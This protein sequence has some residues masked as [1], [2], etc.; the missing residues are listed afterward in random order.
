MIDSA[1]V[2][3]I[4]IGISAYDIADALGLPRPTD[5]QRDVIEAPLSPALVVAGAGSGK[6]ETMANRVL[7]LLANGHLRAGE[8]LGLTFTRKAAGELAA[9][10]RE[11]IGQLAHQGLLPGDYDE[12]EAPVV[13]TYNSFAN[14][15]YRDHAMLLGRESDG[16]VLGEA[17][18][19][20]LARSIVVASGDPRL[21]QLGRNV[22]PITKAVLE[23]SHALSENIVDP[24]RVRAMAARFA[25]IADLPAG[26]KG[27]YPAVAELVRTVGSL[28]VLLDL[29]TA[30]SE[31]KARRGFV[32]YADQVALAL[33]IVR[34]VPRVSADFRERYRVVLL[35]EYQD[36]SVVQTWLLSELF[37]DHAVMAVGDPNQSIYG[38]RGASAANLEQFAHQFGGGEVAN[39][40]LTTSWRNGRK[41]LA[42]A[43]ALVEPLVAHT[44]VRV[45][46][47]QPG[48]G[49]SAVPVELIVEETVL[50]EAQAAARWL[51]AHLART[52]PKTGKPPTAAMLFRARK[53]QPYFMDALRDNDVPFHVLGVGGLMSEPEIADLVSALRVVHD[54]TA[55][56]EL[57]RLLAGSRWRIGVRDLRALSRL[58]SWLRDRDY[59]QKSYDDEVKDALRASV[60]SGEGGSIV[61][62][63]DFL[64]T[65]KP[66]HSQLDGFSE[67]GLERLREAGRT[68]AKLRSRGGLDLLDFVTLVEQELQLDIEVVANDLRALGGANREAFFDAL[69]GYLAVDDS[70]TLGGFLAWLKEAEWRDGLT[71]R[72]EEP[73]PGTVQLLTI[74]G[75]KGL[76]WDAVVVPRMVE[77]EIPS[78]PVEGFGGW[79]GFGALPWPFRGDSAELPEF[80]W[81]RAETRKEVLDAKVEFAEKVR[82][83]HILEERRLAYVAVT[84]ARHWLALTGSFWSTQATAREPSPFLGE[85]E[86]TGVL[87]AATTVGALPL[88]SEHETNPLGDEVTTLVWPLDPLGSRRAKV[89]AAAQ[90]VRD[91]DPSETGRWGPELELLLGE[92]ARRMTANAFVPMP[93]R[94]PASRFKDFVTDP[95]S[96]AAAL[97]RPMPE[98]PYRATRLGTLFHSWVEERYGTGGTAEELDSFA[99][100]LDDGFDAQQVPLEQAELV[101]LQGIFERSPWA[102]R[103]PVEVEREIH[104]VLDGQIIICKIDAVYFD[105]ERYEVVDWKTG[106][107]PRDARDLEDK[108]LQLALYRLAYARWK[109]ID[110]HLID[111]VFYYVSDDA[112]I[113]PKRIFDEDELVELWRASLV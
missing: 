33:E 19:W 24:E 54:P 21:A 93:T 91:A 11:R 112:V 52:D 77:D 100:E 101:R 79:L 56:S 32:E 57:V 42:V 29:A 58:A 30:F 14:T 110:P 18:A 22:D 5:Q 87:A 46:K 17:S 39:F 89:E 104:L 48:P 50:E 10:I 44:R 25:S 43:N 16:D 35:D 28:D 27:D 55:G 53:N 76:E 31:A 84:R 88:A 107:A 63:V 23:L 64:A 51:K 20:Q 65:A 66:G 9:R 2:S 85:L 4:G 36:T 15:I 96:V 60:A 73:E 74:H 61:D 90:A 59:A 70:S 12:F 95:Q 38:W 83:R 40:N 102:L 78:K 111:A 34:R 62:A 67:V 81:E 13:A 45:D 109:N 94:V 82:H 106:K 86:A 71:P 97:R 68:F 1:T 3:S 8:I 103:A 105:G 99:T 41:I 92:R 7:W 72:P 69:G 26:G 80:L 113:R 37:A 49:A 75:S 6:T 98:R 47:L 108:Q